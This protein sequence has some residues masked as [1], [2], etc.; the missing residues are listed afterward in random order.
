MK[1]VF[2]F[3]DYRLY[4]AQRFGGLR[5]RTGQR[6]EAALALGC[7]STFISHVF[8]G[9]VDFSLEQADKLNEFL[10]HS[11]PESHFFLL[12]LQ[13]TRAGTPH[14]KKYFES[15]IESILKERSILA[16]RVPENRSISKTD[17]SRFYSSWIYGAIHVLLS[18]PAFQSKEALS[19]YLNIPASI[20]SEVLEFLVS[21]QLAVYENGLYKM[22]PSHVHLS[23]ASE[24]IGKHHSNWRLQAM[25][26]VDFKKSDDLHYSAV[27]TLSHSDVALIK[28]RIL[29]NMNLNLET[30]KQSKE[31][32]AYVYCFDFFPLR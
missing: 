25:R 24:N 2:D 8:Q 12:L 17:E 3:S 23:G 6:S 30:I 29:A 7:H 26:S 16:T 20:I 5:K 28:E 15:Q 10:G 18:I 32:V 14:L 22:G 19:R 21:L 13:K 31:E 4:L 27:V 11:E 1:N 9:K